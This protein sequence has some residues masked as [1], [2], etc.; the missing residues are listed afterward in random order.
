VNK[1]SNVN[2]YALSY[3]RKEDLINFCKLVY[4]GSNIHMDRKYKKA[5]DM[6]DSLQ[7][8]FARGVSPRTIYSAQI[9]GLLLGN[10]KDNLE[11]KTDESQIG[12]QRLHAEPTLCG[13][14]I[15]QSL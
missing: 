4:S 7:S 1:K 15:V 11:G 8:A 2:V 14:G 12:P 13:D 10:A 9:K 3:S 6:L 5:M